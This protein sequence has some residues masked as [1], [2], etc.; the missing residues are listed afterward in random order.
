MTEKASK[1]TWVEIHDIVLAVGERASQVPEDTQS[2]PLEM[3]VKGFLIADA[4]IGDQAEITTRS[5]RQLKGTLTAINPAYSHQFGSP[6]PELLM[7]GD[8]LRAILKAKGASP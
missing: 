7:I 4:S 6:L 2:V 1:N 5:G 3:K 8:E